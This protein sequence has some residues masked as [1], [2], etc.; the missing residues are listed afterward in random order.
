MPANERPWDKKGRDDDD[1]D[2]PRRRRDA[3]DDDEGDR[4]RRRKRDEDDDYDHDHPRGRAPESNGLATAGLILGILSFCGGVAGIPAVICALLALGKP[5][6]RGL[7][8][9]GLLLGGLGMLVWAGL[10][11]VLFTGGWEALQFAGGRQKDGNNLKQIGLA[12][13][14]Q[15]SINGRM[16]GPYAR[17]NRGQVNSGLSWRVVLLPYVEDNLYRQFDL[18]QAWDSPRNRPH[19]N[20]AIRTFTSPYGGELAS[21][22][23]PYRVFYGGGA[24]FDEDGKAV[25]LRDITDGTSNTIMAVHA[26]EQLPWAEPRELRYDPNPKAPLPQLWAKDMPG[27]QVVMADGSVRFVK[28]TVSEPTLRAAITRNGGEV[29]GKDW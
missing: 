9:T 20:T 10:A 2:R 28:K 29:L 3:D 24:L 19:S 5:T 25:R 12:F 26:A 23:T 8:I 17:Y 16:T 6:G 22:Q 13:H 15:E 27:T 18:S 7:A 11:V 1:E 4:P 14:D 21:T